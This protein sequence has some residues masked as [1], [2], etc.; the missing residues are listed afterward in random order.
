M[1]NSELVY[2]NGEL[3]PYGEA[4]ISVEDRGF[5]FSDG[6]YEV[7][8]VVG[9]NA[10]RIES[11]LDRFEGGARALEIEL[12]LTRDGVHEAVLEAARANGVTEGTVYVQLSRG[13][14]PRKHAFPEGARPTL[15]I[16]ARLFPGPAPEH[17]EKGVE[18]LTQPDLRWGYCEVKTV[19]LLPNVIAFQHARSE[20]CFEA[21]LVRDGIVTEGS[22]SSTFCVRDG[23]VYTHPIDNILPSITRKYLIEAYRTE[24][25]EVR[26]VGVRIEEYRA[27]DEILLAGTTTE[28]MPVVQV[29]GELVGSGRPGELTRL[30]MELYRRD[31]EA[32][33]AGK[34]G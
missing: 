14:A 4:K 12:P 13:A 31:L 26:E 9:G 29:D 5:N 20:G 21:I 23:I 24:G 28:V 6:I 11:H 17:F 2:L 27:A 25:V 15:V 18:V 33:R 30:G 34:A 19:G 3:V 7:I 32:V 1:T 8:R 10:F 16:L 22:H